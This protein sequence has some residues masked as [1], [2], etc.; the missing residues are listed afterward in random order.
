VNTAATKS[1]ATGALLTAAIVTLALT[2]GYIHSTLGGLLF[3]LN[4]LGYAAAAV[5]IV[6]GAAAPHPFIARFS[7]LPRLG[8][9]GYAA[10]TI[11]AWVVMGPYFSTAYIA[12]AVEVGLITLLVVDSIRV[13]GSPMGM[14]RQA[15]A[16]VFGRSAELAR[17]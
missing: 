6:I 1:R 4:A 5:A 3:T 10:T 9:I 7:W 13:Y 2:T 11:G 12:K 16:S 8:L 14:I 17:A 15:F